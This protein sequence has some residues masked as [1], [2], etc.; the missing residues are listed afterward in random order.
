M[1]D[2]YGEVGAEWLRNLSALLTDCAARWSLT[3]EPPF[4]PLTY[5][6]VAPAIRADGTPV[7]LKVGV[8]CDGL[9]SEIEALRLFNGQGAVRLLDANSK[10]GALL[11]ERLTPGLSLLSVAD[12]EQAAAIAAETM[13]ELWQPVP[14]NH[15]FLTV[16]DWF[17][18]LA[19]LRQQFD[20]GTGPLPP[21]LVEKAEALCA[22][23]TASTTAPRLLHGD[24]HH[25]NILRAERTPWLVIDPKGVVGDPAFEPSAFLLN[26]TPQSADVLRRR[27]AI[28][29]EALDVPREWVCGWGLARAVLSACWTLEDHGTGWE[30]AIAVAEA[31]SAG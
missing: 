4:I 17:L 21:R 29:A 1:I 15:V 9:T 18:G 24:L 11:L 30:D 19:R 8:P 28:F 10:S 22:E 5:N 23:L 7:V 26:P 3:L 14:E 2:V 13:R 27:V 31:L 12:D 25:G 20:G 6:Y 16:G